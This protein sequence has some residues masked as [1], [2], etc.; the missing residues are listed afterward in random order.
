MW[1]EEA[2]ETN[3]ENGFFNHSVNVVNSDGPIY[4][5]FKQKEGINSQEFL[6]SIDG[7][8][9]PGFGLNALMNICK[10][11]RCS[12]DECTKT[13]SKSI[14][15]TFQKKK[16]RKQQIEINKRYLGLPLSFS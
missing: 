1:W 5:I 6:E 16:F 14:H 7:P 10:K 15:I 3:K 9:G 13:L 8:T 2:V 11:Y 4:C 12:T